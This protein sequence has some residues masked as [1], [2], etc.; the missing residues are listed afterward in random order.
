MGLLVLW[1]LRFEVQA[2]FLTLRRRN[3]RGSI[4]QWVHATTGL[5][6]GDNVANRR[7]T[8][9][10]RHDTIPT[11]RDTAVRRS[12]EGKCLQEEAELVLRL[13]VRDAHDLEHP[14]LD[15]LAV[16]TDGTAADLI[17]VA[18]DVVCVSQC[19]AWVLVEGIQELRLR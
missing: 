19:L 3:G 13:F 8:T 12:A 4:R 15:V 1:L 17:A 14:L 9:Q 10:Q 7:E 18:H 11:E 6:E 16:D 2:G 5:R